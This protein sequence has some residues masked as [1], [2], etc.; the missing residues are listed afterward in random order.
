MTCKNK[1][2]MKIIQ[3]SLLQKNNHFYLKLRKK[4]QSVKNIYLC[5]KLENKENDK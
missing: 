5:K 4:I 3:N 1:I 2:K